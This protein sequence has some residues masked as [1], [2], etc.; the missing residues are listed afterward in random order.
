MSRK[1]V[2]TVVQVDTAEVVKTERFQT[3]HT[4]TSERDSYNHIAY[5]DEW[6]VR[7]VATDEKF[8]RQLYRQELDQIDLVAVISAANKA[9]CGGGQ[10]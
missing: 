2:L 8:E 1:Y 9:D 5:A 7:E 4:P 6:D 10:P 3:K